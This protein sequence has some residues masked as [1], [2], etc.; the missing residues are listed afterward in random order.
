VTTALVAGAT[1]DARAQQLPDQSVTTAWVAD[2]RAM[3]AEEHGTAGDAETVREFLAL[4]EVRVLA[5]ERGLD[6]DAITDRVG[7]LDDASVADLADRIRDQ[8]DQGQLVG[9]DTLVISSTAVIIVLLVLI[10]VAV[11]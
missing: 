5:A 8:A 1:Y 7:T 9:G 11:D 4:E 2:L 6:L 10:L 3:V